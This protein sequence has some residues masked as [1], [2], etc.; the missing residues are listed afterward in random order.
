MANEFNG[1]NY[2]NCTCNT[3]SSTEN[4][5]SKCYACKGK[6]NSVI[7][8]QKQILNQVRVPSS[9]YMMNLAA[10]TIAN[11]TTTKNNQASDRENPS[12]QVI[13]LSSNGNSTR[14][15]LLGMKPGASSVGGKGVDI[16]H[17]SYA[18]Y[19][20]RKKAQFIRTE[21]T[22]SPTPLFGNKTKAYGILSQSENCCGGGCITFTATCNVFLDGGLNFSTFGNDNQ[23]LKAS[24]K[25]LT[26]FVTGNFLT[27]KVQ[28]TEFNVINDTQIIV[29]LQGVTVDLGFGGQIYTFATAACP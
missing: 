18:R 14:S 29:I 27:G 26:Y 4:S 1:D 25:N 7:I 17:N 10:L 16:K 21:N 5:G 3:T 28:V 12:K 20:G 11:R 19:L 23:E 2:T 9:L 15:T 22:N 13:Y 24:N 8:T 6:T